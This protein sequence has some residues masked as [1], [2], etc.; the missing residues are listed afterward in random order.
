[1]QVVVKQHCRMYCS[2]HR[3]TTGIDLPVMEVNIFGSTPASKLTEMQVLG[4]L[5][6]LDTCHDISA[7]S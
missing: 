5:G 6:M 1:M 4:D 3:T 2:K 7:Y